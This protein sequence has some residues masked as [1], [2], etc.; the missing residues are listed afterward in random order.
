MP[1]L[2]IEHITAA[3]L[4][5]MADAPNNENIRKFLDYM[6]DV[7]INEDENVKFPREIRNHYNNF[8]ARTNNHV[9]GW[10]T[11]LYKAVLKAHPNI[12]EYIN[13]LK[14]QQQ[15]FET[16]ILSLDAGNQTPKLNRNYKKLNEKIRSLT[17]IYAGDSDYMTF[18]DNIKH[19]LPLQSHK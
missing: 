16:A 7:W 13:I 1:F 6:V 3:W 8:S 11:A 4:E 2:K 15:N 17:T 14:N 12:Y 10:H 19:V 18:L 9:E 5:I